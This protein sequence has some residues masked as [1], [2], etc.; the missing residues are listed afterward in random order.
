MA[1]R[2]ESGQRFAEISRIPCILAHMTDATA[3]SLVRAQ[4][5]LESFRL[6]PDGSALVYALRRVRGADYESHLWMRPMRGGRPRQLTRGRVRDGAPAISPDG[7]WLAFVRSP[8]GADEAV[9]QAWVLPLDGGEPWRLTRLKHGVGSVHWSPDSARLALVA[10]AGDHRFVVG[11]ER[12]GQTPIARR[13]TRL[14]FRDD[15]T[16]HVVRRSHLWLMGF[17]AGAAPRQLTRG[18]F[19][20]LHPTWSPDGRRIAFAADPGPDTNINPQL[21]IFAVGTEAAK[22]RVRELA[23]LRGDADW[24]SFS[25][26]GRRLAFIGT[27]VE[28]PPDEVP[29]AV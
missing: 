27:D 9:G 7:R 23:A 2:A 10:Q 8:V 21:R 3:E 16:G 6:M 12:K 26:D 15:E 19:D 13:I 14:D 1:H 22:P 24:P 5:A 17:R 4:I 29:P 25:P 11:E 20:V 18:D 28:D